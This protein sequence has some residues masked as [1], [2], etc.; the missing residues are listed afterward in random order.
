MDGA[1]AE[2]QSGSTATASDQAETPAD[3]DSPPA[4]SQEQEQAQVEAPAEEPQEPTVDELQAQVAKLTKD[5]N[6]ERARNIGRQTAADRDAKV[7]VLGD[8]LTEIQDTLGALADRSAGRTTEEEY[9]AR[10]AS[11]RETRATAEAGRTF[12]SR[13]ES[14]GARL[15]EAVKDAKGELLVDTASAEFAEVQRLW[16]AG[17]GQKGERGLLLLQEGLA[18]AERLAREGLESRGIQGDAPKAEAETKAEDSPKPDG[19]GDAPS[20]AGEATAEETS[21]MEMAVGVNGASG[22]NDDWRDLPPAKMIA[23]G[24]QEKARGA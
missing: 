21:P 18:M 6:D 11:A 19:G 16:K 7:D 3:G 9:D 8:R 12:E 14:I 13:S 15:V 22:V 10:V 20:G 4:G 24:E 1:E 5:Y 23:A 2:D 17:Q